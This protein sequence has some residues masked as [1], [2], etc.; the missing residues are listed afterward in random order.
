MARSVCCHLEYKKA[1][2]SAKESLELEKIQGKFDLEQEF[3]LQIRSDRLAGV[4]TMLMWIGVDYKIIISRN[5]SGNSTSSRGSPG[6]KRKPLFTGRVSVLSP[7]DGAVL[8]S[9]TMRR[10]KEENGKE[11]TNKDIYAGKQYRCDSMDPA[12]I[13]AAILKLMDKLYAEND[14]QLKKYILSVSRPDRVTPKFCAENY[15][16]DFLHLRYP[17]SEGE[18]NAA[19]KRR[20]LEIY[21]KLPYVYTHKVLARDVNAM[22][23]KENVVYDT[24][25]L[26]R[27][28]WDYLL[29]CRKCIGKNPFP[30]EMIRITSVEKR[31]RMPLKRGN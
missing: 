24:V 16:D 7:V 5:D 31:T 14:S 19:R 11:Y 20:I 30:S 1:I 28:F 10:K 23:K 3:D 4:R 8:R 15:V 22:I 18:R 26:C 13:A 21:R 2:I 6:T 27:E 9:E 29:N 25:Q 17:G 12:D